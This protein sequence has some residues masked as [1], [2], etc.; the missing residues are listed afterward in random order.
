[1]SSVAVKSIRGFMQLVVFLV[2]A[3]FAPAWTIR[4]WQAWVYLAVFAGAS[5][6]IT[7][8][9]W[10]HDPNLL[11]RR[12]NAGAAA[13]KEKSQKRIQLFAS[14]AF[15]GEIILPSIDHR[16]AWSHVPFALTIAGD[17][18][19]L[20]GFFFVF[21]VFR[22]NTFTSATIEVD[23]AQRVVSTGPYAILRH[24]M[25]A[26]V[27]IMLFGTPIALGSWWGI[28]MFFPMVVVIVLRILNEEKFLRRHL[29]GYTDYCQ[30][31]KFRL[32]PWIW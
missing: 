5:A 26:A 2:I 24:P 9:L 11:E 3:L 4:Y 8:Y 12:I 28:L 23:S 7:A 16:F 15:L 22:E 17:L 25:Y 6:L 14:I 10:K 20:L 27:L 19:V 32:A 30:R 1:M 21:L 18:L 13:E 31:V 29:P